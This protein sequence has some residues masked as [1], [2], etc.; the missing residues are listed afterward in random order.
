MTLSLSIR[1]VSHS[2]GDRLVLDS[3]NLVVPRESITAIIGPSGVGKTTLLRLIAGFEAPDKGSI[4]V[5]GELVAENS[6]LIIP[7]QSRGVTVVPQDGALFSHLTVGGNVAFGLKHRRSDATRAR[8]N[9]VLEIV[10]LSKYERHR[11][12]ELSGG[13]QQRV[14][15]ARALAPN[16]RVVL[17]DEPFAALDAGLREQVREETVRALRATKATAIWVTHDQSEALSTADQVA[18]MLGGRIQQVAAPAILYQHPISQQVAEFVGE[19]FVISGMSEVSGKYVKCALGD[20]VPIANECS[21]GPVKVV[22]RP[23]QL[24]IAQASDESSVSVL[25]EGSKFF[26]HDG[27][28]EGKFSTGERVV[29]RL[30]A[31]QLPQAGSRVSVTT[32]GTLLA[33]ND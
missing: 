21:A 1:D 30:Q 4:E 22:V 9:Q 20:S 7:S 33:Y 15:L 31:D 10:G 11:P 29:I 28:V 23:E 3:I 2:Y 25:V 18:V 8:V 12:S 19:T 5:E 24:S 14:A 6:R 17:L 13:M 16:P 32:H 26:G 27:V